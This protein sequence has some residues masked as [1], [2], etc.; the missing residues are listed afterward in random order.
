[1]IRLLSTDFDGTLVNHNQEPAV[2]PAMFEVFAEMRAGG[3]VWAINTGRAVHHIVEGLEEYG[4]GIQ[5]DFIVTSERDI[6]RPKAG[7]GWEDFGDWNRRSHAAHSELYEEA[8]P[9]IEEIN[10]YLKKNTKALPINELSGLGIIASDEKEMEQ[11]ARYIDTLRPRLPAF[12]YQ[13]NTRY[14]RFCHSD[15]SKGTALAELA[16]LLGV[17]KGEIFAAGDHYNDISMLDGRF[18]RWVACPANSAEAVKAIVHEAGGYVAHAS[19]SDGV[20]EALR[21]FTGRA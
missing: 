5:P 1:M 12:H 14:M 3:A 8:K 19:F 21:F 6:F 11:I 4:F 2:S 15:Y 9:L 13:R 10:I 16:R 20:V 18:A 17:A 7:G